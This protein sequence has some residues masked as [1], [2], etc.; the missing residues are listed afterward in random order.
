MRIE[1][2]W[3][4]EEAALQRRLSELKEWLGEVQESKA[5]SPKPRVPKPG[6]KV[7][8]TDARYRRP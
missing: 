4:V 6:E 3:E 5:K 7:V 8:G 2:L 1:D